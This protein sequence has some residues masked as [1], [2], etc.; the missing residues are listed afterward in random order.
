MHVRYAGAIPKAIKAWCDKNADKVYEVIRWGDGGCKYDAALRKGWQDG[1]GA[2][3]VYG[4][5]A[6]DL[7]NSLRYCEPCEC[8]ECRRD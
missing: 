7:I 4:S 2:H 6:R 3:T 1:M 5:T 8:K